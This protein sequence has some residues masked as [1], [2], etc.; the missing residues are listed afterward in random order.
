MLVQIGSAST[1]RPTRSCCDDQLN[2]PNIPRS[3]SV[4]AA[5]MPACAPR[6]ARSAMPTTTPCARVSSPPSNASCWHRADS[7]HRLRRDMRSSNS[8]KASTIDDDA[9]P[10][11]DISH[12][13]IMSGGI[14]RRGRSRRAV[15][16]AVK[17]KPFGRPQEGAVLDRRCARRPHHRAGRDGRMAPPRAE[18]KNVSKRNP[19]MPSDQ[20]A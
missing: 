4:A 14:Q 3:N 19:S 9:I 2:P 13:S 6:W 11:S 17:D 8:S 16:A 15:L 7:R 1:D 10:R 18:P 5:V 20:I 12:R